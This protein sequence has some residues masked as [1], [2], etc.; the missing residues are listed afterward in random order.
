MLDY[1]IIM[2]LTI[3]PVA[4]CQGL[5]NQQRKLWQFHWVYGIL[6]SVRIVCSV[7]R[8]WAIER[9]ILYNVWEDMLWN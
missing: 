5:F 1:R 9:E 4:K 2:V 6:R 8:F 3:I 7:N